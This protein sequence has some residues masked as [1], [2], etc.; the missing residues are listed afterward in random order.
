METVNK[1]LLALVRSVTAVN[2]K[3]IMV[4]RLRRTSG[5]IIRGAWIVFSVE[6]GCKS[7]SS[8]GA[9]SVDILRLLMRKDRCCRS[10][11]HLIKMLGRLEEG[12]GHSTKVLLRG[13]STRPNHL[14]SR[15]ANSYIHIYLDDVLQVEG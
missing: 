13:S 2:C 7:L 12:H 8:T 3:I 9:I 5:R 14:R 1:P 11:A 6:L 10:G 4:A 15:R